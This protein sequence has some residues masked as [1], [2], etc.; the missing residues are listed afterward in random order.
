MNPNGVGRPTSQERC[1]CPCFPA[2]A[3]E[4]HVAEMPQGLG[5]WACVLGGEQGSFALHRGNFQAG[6]WLFR[7]S[8]FLEEPWKENGEETAAKKGWH[9]ELSGSGRCRVGFEPGPPTT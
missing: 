1:S 7:L 3:R 6:L 4:E 8:A 2:Q 5:L 9:W